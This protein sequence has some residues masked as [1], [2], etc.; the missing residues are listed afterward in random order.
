MIC[1]TAFKKTYYMSTDDSH[2]ACK[3]VMLADSNQN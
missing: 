3:N 2:Q 1:S